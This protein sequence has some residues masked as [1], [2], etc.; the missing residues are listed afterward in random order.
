MELFNKIVELSRQGFFCSQIMMILALES[1][2]KEN[3]DLIR[4][5]GGLNGGLGFTGDVCGCLT[6]GCCFLSYFLNKGKADE[7]EDPALRDAIADYI[8]W[9]RDMTQS[10]YHGDTCYDITKNKAVKR[11]ENCP[12]LIEAAMEKCM[13]L[14]AER[15][16]I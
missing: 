13:E 9:F 2:G 3:P 10:A 14:L 12:P 15:G 7:L 4:A 8:R 1:E 11:I 16:V 6:G 5:M